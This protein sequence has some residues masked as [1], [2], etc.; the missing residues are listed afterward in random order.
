MEG[1]L[2]LR[3]AGVCR[4]VTGGEP[5][6]IT[7]TDAMG[8]VV[9]AVCA[10]NGLVAALMDGAIYLDVIVVAD[11]LETAVTD[12]ILA[13]LL[14][15]EPPVHPR[16]TAVNDDESYCSHKLKE[17]KAPP[18]P[19]PHGAGA[20]EVSHIVGGHTVRKSISISLPPLGFAAFIAIAEKE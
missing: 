7:D 4:G 9:L 17:K 16:G 15:G 18:Q 13:T 20:F 2:L 6:F 5:P 11:I 12:V 8:V 14:E 19:S 10:D 1:S 3:R